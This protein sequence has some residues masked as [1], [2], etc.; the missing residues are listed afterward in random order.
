VIDGRGPGAQSSSSGAVPEVVTDPLDRPL[1]SESERRRVLSTVRLRAIFAAVL[2]VVLV[3]YSLLVLALVSA[4]FNEVSPAVA[5]DLERKTRRAVAELSHAVDLGLLL[6]DGDMVR[7]AFDEH[8]SDQDVVYLAAR[9]AAGRLVAEG[10]RLPEGLTDPARGAGPSWQSTADFLQASRPVLIEGHEAGRVGI[11]V[12]KRRLA[13]GV[14]LQRQILLAT[15]GGG[16]VALLLGLFF[17][18]FYV[19]PLVKLTSRAFERLEVRTREALEASRLKSEFLA[20]VSHEIRTPMN[21]VLG[22]SELL[23]RTALDGKQ[24]RFLDTIH[25]SAEALMVVLNDVLDFSKLEAGKLVLRQ[26]EFDLRRLLEDAIDL[27][28][29]RA[30]AKGLELSAVVGPGTPVQLCG[31]PDRLRQV[32]LNLVG[33]AVK[34][35]RRGEIVLDAQEVPRDDGRRWVRF[36]VRD[37]GIGIPPEELASIFEVFSQVDGSLTREQGGTGLGLAICR[38]LVRQMGG[39]I[40]VESELGQGSTFSFELPFQAAAGQSTSGTIRRELRGAHVL[41]VGGTDG[42]REALESHLAAWEATLARVETLAE[43]GA[44]LRET[45]DPPTWVMVDVPPG[46][47]AAERAQAVD[48]AG[49]GEAL[50]VVL[51]VAGDEVLVPAPYREV[52]QKPLRRAELGRVAVRLLRRRGATLEPA[53]PVPSLPPPVDGAGRTILVAEDNPINQEVVLEMLTESGFTA[54][55][56]PNGA[57]A[58]RVYEEDP[59]RYAAVLMDCQ[60]PV[61][62]G[63]DASRRI[64]ALE[65]A[66]G[67][68]RVPILACTAHALESERRRAVEAG[69]DD[70]L[71]KPI[72]ARVLLGALGSWTG[73]R[74]SVPA[75][76]PSPARPVLDGSMSRSAR[77]LRVSLRSLPETMDAVREA[78]GGPDLPALREAAHKL[79]GGT[80]AL[81]ATPLSEAARA[82]EMAAREKRGDEV[83]ALLEGLEARFDEALEA[84][85]REAA[86]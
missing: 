21:G 6:E 23:S 84:L 63:Y 14:E 62:D 47:S 75:P 10:G 2:T 45:D 27:S 53:A 9:T 44:R 65:E 1:L 41:L 13:A 50:P 35:T 33:N 26:T 24:R 57:E 12:S 34:F 52:L 59:D 76:P 72:S 39:S 29:G 3:A 51:M 7:A 11:V 43:A 46:A 70:Y 61:L 54:F 40:A 5:M 31:D 28:T 55:V 74:S 82:L 79:K 4:I 86:A 81:G 8:L 38:A 64:R 17:V 37:T 56:V 15:L 36:R 66:A 22:M 18:Q 30:H 42:V 58:V 32:L 80:L 60:M 25:R 68:P 69:M 73:L 77:L 85:R 48:D 49:L 20:N 19:G 16:A 83:P 67:W 71:T 78:A